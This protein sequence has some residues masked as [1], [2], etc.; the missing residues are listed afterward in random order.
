MAE[1]L[2]D[3]RGKTKNDRNRFGEWVE[4]LNAL[5]GTTS[6]EMA[7]R[8]DVD[9]SAISIATHGASGMRPKT[10]VALI[11][12]YQ[13]L[14]QEREVPLP[15]NWEMHFGLSWYD[16]AD[17]GGRGDQTLASLQY[18]AAQS[19]HATSVIVALIRENDRLRRENE[20]LARENATLRRNGS[21]NKKRL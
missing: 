9:R 4:A 5:L 10:V 20:R 11:Q 6:K 7:E 18:R 17:L 14:A 8:I 3:G 1:S 2:D 15:T 19:E 12:A 16:S 21:D 13:I